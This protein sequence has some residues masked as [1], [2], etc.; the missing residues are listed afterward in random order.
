MFSRL[1]ERG[2]ESIQKPATSV[3]E[4]NTFFM[5]LRVCK[6]QS[7]ILRLTALPSLD[8]PEKLTLHFPYQYLALS[9]VAVLY[10][11]DNNGS[12]Y[13]AKQICHEYISNTSSTANPMIWHPNFHDSQL[14][15]FAI[16]SRKIQPA[17]PYMVIY[18]ENSF[19]PGS[20]RMLS[21]V[22]LKTAKRTATHIFP[23]WLFDMA[24]SHSPALAIPLDVNLLQISLDYLCEGDACDLALDDN[25]VNAHFRARQ[26]FYLHFFEWNKLGKELS[27]KAIGWGFEIQPKDVRN[28][29]AKGDA[30]PW[31]RGEHPAL[32]GDTEKLLLEWITN[33]AEN[34]AIVNQT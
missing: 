22:G 33:N 2:K 20:R 15:N 24:W 8:P 14:P 11:L 30:I 9:R 26:I 18:R 16:N 34:H 4:E 1:W 13:S 3:I 19:R 31:G 10:P 7:P 17:T 6:V 5:C 28:A 32:E 27:L 12:I 23:S 25:F 21:C 29:L